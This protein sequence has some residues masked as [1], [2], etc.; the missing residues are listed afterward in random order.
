MINKLEDIY[1]MTI[2]HMRYGK[3]AI[4]EA[5]CYSTCVITLQD[6][7]ESQYDPHNFMKKEWE[8][9]NYGVGVDIN[10]AFIDF[11]KRYR[12]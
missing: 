7:E 5:S 10:S 6:D 9:I 3:F 2:I 4:V 11:K 12:I 8:H 1:P